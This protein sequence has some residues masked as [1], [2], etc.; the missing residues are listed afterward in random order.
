[1]TEIKS[2]QEENIAFVM[3]NMA[4]SLEHQWSFSGKMTSWAAMTTAHVTTHITLVSLHD[5]VKLVISSRR[6][7]F[8]GSKKLLD[9]I[10]RIIVCDD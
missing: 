4:A 9:M 3:S 2:F 5:A 1:M 8:E 7:K 6:D 10:E